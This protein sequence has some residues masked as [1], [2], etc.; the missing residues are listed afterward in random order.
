MSHIYLGNVQH[1]ECM[2]QE[3]AMGSVADRR[4]FIFVLMFLCI[5]SLWHSLDWNFFKTISSY[6]RSL[7][8]LTKRLVAFMRRSKASLAGVAVTWCEWYAATVA[9]RFTSEYKWVLHVRHEQ[10]QS[11]LR[12]LHLKHQTVIRHL[13]LLSFDFQQSNKLID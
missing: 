6:Y 3:S 11:S 12:F 7:L 8:Q 1:V 2:Y 10:E 13:Q 5:H 4:S 9:L